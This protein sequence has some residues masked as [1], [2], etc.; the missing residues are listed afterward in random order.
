M[1]HLDVMKHSPETFE[2]EYQYTRILLNSFV[3]RAIVNRLAATTTVFSRLHDGDGFFVM[4]L[5]REPIDEVID[6]SCKILQVIHRL[7]QRGKLKYIPVRI[8]LR[9]VTASVFLLKALSL[10]IWDSQVNEPLDI[11]DRAIHALRRISVDDL[12]L[13]PRYATLIQVQA[14]WLRKRLLSDPEES[15]NGPENSQLESI[16]TGEPTLDSRYPSAS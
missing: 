6:S 9:A 11:L 2:I 10:R 4:P 1:N 14:N 3:M 7:D 8:V 13:G 5:E 15:I 12:H 16:E